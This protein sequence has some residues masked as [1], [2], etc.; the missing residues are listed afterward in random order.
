MPPGAGVDAAGMIDANGPLEGIM[1]ML[2]D[3]V[4]LE[5]IEY[6]HQ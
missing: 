1:N 2:D 6:W 5:E 4:A 3:D